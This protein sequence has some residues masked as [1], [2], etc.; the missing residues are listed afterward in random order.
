MAKYS[1][2]YCA[3]QFCYQH[4][5]DDPHKAGAFVLKENPSWALLVSTETGVIKFHYLNG[6][7]LTPIPRRRATDV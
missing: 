4:S 5:F 3:R 2:L 7:F 6:K 1:L